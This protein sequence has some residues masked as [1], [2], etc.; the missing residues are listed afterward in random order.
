MGPNE[1]TP[2]QRGVLVE[3][4]AQE[5]G[6]AAIGPTPVA[7]QQGHQEPKLR[8]GDVARLDSLGSLL[9]A[10]ADAQVCPRDHRHVVGT[11]TD[12]KRD[13]PAVLP[14][15]LY[16]LALLGRGEAAADAAA[17][18]H[19]KL[20]ELNRQAL[21]KD[22]LQSLPVQH[23][24]ARLAVLHDLLRLLQL[25]LDI[26][27][28]AAVADE[29]QVHVLGEEVAGVGDVH[30]CLSLVACQHP[31]PDARGLQGGDGLGHPVLEP[32]LHRREAR[33]LQLLLHVSAHL[34]HTLLVV[35]HGVLR[36]R[37]CGLPAGEVCGGHFL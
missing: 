31:K 3:V 9:A 32:V 34:R 19:G 36:F 15:L 12:G 1:I 7:Q 22:Q 21:L 27:P 20:I 8:D 13:G 23:Q 35:L 6:D 33:K 5:G 28:G 18:E 24:A 16:D 14:H 17:G 11:V 26:L 25:H 29:G 30:G 2:G 4:V 10:D 37:P